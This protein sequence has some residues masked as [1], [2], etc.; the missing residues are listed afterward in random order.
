MILHFSD[1]YLLKGFLWFIY[2]YFISESNK[3]SPDV[4]STNKL[5]TSPQINKFLTREPPDGCEKVKIVE[6]TRWVL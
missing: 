5:A 1:I 4:D 6:E 3:V 2:Q